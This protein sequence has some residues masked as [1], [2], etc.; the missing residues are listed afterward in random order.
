[1]HLY[2]IPENLADLLLLFVV[3][4]ALPPARGELNGKNY[5]KANNGV[6]SQPLQNYEAAMQHLSLT[7]HPSASCEALVPE[8]AYYTYICLCLSN[9]AL[10][11]YTYAPIKKCLCVTC[12]S[13]SHI[14]V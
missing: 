8:R 1:M 10:G 2:C 6:L 7:H 9:V 3:V 14:I 5:K 11:S 4:V 13:L 12:T